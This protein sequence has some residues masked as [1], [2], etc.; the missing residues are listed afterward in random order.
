MVGEFAHQPSVHARLGFADRSA[1][2]RRV[3]GLWSG[4]RGGSYLIWTSVGGAH[5]CG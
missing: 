5:L 2:R 3:W 4:R 1:W